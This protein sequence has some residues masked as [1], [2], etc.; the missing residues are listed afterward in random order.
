MGAVGDLPDYT[1][2]VDPIP[3][4]TIIDTIVNK[5]RELLCEFLL[6]T[7]CCILNGCV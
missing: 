1:E 5:Y 3:D 7:D 4:R 6:I 2:G